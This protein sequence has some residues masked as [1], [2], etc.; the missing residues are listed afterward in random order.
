MMPPVPIKRYPTRLAVRCV[1]CG[2]RG[3]VSVFLDKAPRL[4]C[5]ICGDGNP[6]VGG[7]DFTRAWAVK[8]LKGNLKHGGKFGKSRRT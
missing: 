1:A 8:R 4:R 3:E 5:S 7:R 6:V 2:H